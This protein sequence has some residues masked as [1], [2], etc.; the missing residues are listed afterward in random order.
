MHPYDQITVES[1]VGKS[2]IKWSQGE[3]V[4]GAFIAE[5]DFGV[6]EP[7]RAALRDL[8]E[9][10]LFGYAPAWMV[11]ELQEATAELYAQE[12]GWR[13]P[14]RQVAPLPDVIAGFAAFLDVFTAPGAPVILPTPAYMPFLRVP[15]L[16]ECRIIEVPMRR[17]PEAST[18]WRLDPADLETAFAAA[19]AEL[20]AAAAS[21]DAASRS[22]AGE[23]PRHRGP[24]L[25]LCNP[26]NP[27]GKVH[28]REEMAQIARVVQAHD[29][30]VF[31][32]EIHA[33]VV[34]SGARHVPYASTGAAAAG[35]TVTAT[36]AS[37]A[38]N[39]PGLRCAQLLF[40]DEADATR[41]AERGEFVSKSA[42]NPGMLATTAAY[43][44]ARVWARE[45]RDYLE[46]NR[47]EL[48]DLLT[49]HLPGVGWIPPQATFL[50]WLDVS[51]LG[52]PGCPQEF[53]LE[54]AAVSLTDGAQ[55]GQGLGGH[56]RL[57]FGMPRPVLREAV[58]RMGRAAAQLA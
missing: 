13:V 47:D 48:G 34:Y 16:H 14:A 9:R 18:P 39:I 3:G 32:D 19:D 25:I 26:H 41:W 15:G 7:I 22:A 57:N 24:V 1:L 44:E 23:G 49:Q 11:R 51:A 6:A 4:I 8:D 52:I 5:T 29:G 12:H 20:A 36:A 21:G 55:C 37:K 38:F 30:W 53:F 50:A 31:S 46:G 54:R 28:T 42:S 35:H 56:V 2:G 45:T 10:D 33:P 27:T 43:R 17:D 58:E 40:S